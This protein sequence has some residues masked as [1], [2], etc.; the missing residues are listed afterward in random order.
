MERR[1]KYAGYEVAIYASAEHLL[2]RLPCDSVLGCI[3]LDLRMPGLSGS[4]L[5]ERLSELGSTLPYSSLAIPISPPQ[6]RPSRRVRR[7]F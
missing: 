4:E 7:T 1:L 6:C 2:D 3:L 5:Q